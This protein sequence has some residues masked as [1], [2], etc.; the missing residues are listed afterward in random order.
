MLDVLI[1]LITT[2]LCSFRVY[3]DL[4]KPALTGIDDENI[5]QVYGLNL[6]KG[7][8]YVYT[9]NFEHVEG[10]TSPLWVALHYLLYKITAHPEPYILVCSVALTALAIYWSLGIARSISA[11]LELPR[12]T[13][14][15]PVVAIAAQPNYFHWTVVTMMDQGLWGAIVLGLTFV[16]VRHVGAADG[17]KRISLLGMA[18]CVASVLARPESMLLMPAMLALAA[19]I[20]AVNKGVGSAIRYVAPYLAAVVLTLAALTALR[21]MYFGH[22]LP[23]TYYA[24]VSSNPVD[25]IVQ[26]IHYVVGFLNSNILVVPSVLAAALGLLVGVQSGWVSVRTKT[27]LSAAHS[28]LLLVGGTA[29]VVIATTI[30]EGG[31][32]F[33]GFRMLQPYVPLMSVALMF[34]VP[35]LADWSRLALSRAAGVTWSAGIVVAI[36]VASYSS[37]AATDKGLKEDFELAVDGR[38][39]GDL[40]NVLA[41]P[42]LPDVG[43][44]PAGGIAVTYHGRVVDLLGL[45]WAEMAH[46]SGRRTGMVGH[47]AFNLDVFWKHPPQLMLPELAG[48]K[49][50]LKEKQTPANFELWVLHG[51][52]NQPRFREAY[53]PVLMHVGDGGVFAYARTEFID[54]HTHDPRVEALAWER[55]RPAATTVTEA[56]N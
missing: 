46:A 29:A 23:N 10:A 18:L 25:N 34:Y 35:L 49:N 28:I 31:D 54:R 27:Q 33:P 42:N 50:P 22:P 48:G 40:L 44:I 5:T 9:P 8:G 6:A 3:R 1:A 32:H 52:M 51:L 37:F 2:A 55:F 24:K 53:R 13:L 17:P 16:L 11:A 15:I 4:G 41:D 14:W 38:Q 12:W 47:S 45:N 21:M 7:F 30:L 56:A 36:V 43:V 20:I 39:I 26:G 19:L